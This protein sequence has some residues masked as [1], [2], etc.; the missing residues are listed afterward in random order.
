MAMASLNASLL[1]P[2]GCAQ[3]AARAPSIVPNTRMSESSARHAAISQI[4]PLANQ[5]KKPGVSEKAREKKTKKKSLR[6]NASMDKD[7]RLLAVHNGL[8]QQALLEL[9]VSEYLD[10]AFA[11]GACICRR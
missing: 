6:L 9:A 3:P 2:K 10:R 5:A 4:A 11:K 1:A 7:L 8:S